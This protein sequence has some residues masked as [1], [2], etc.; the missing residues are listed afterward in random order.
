MNNDQPDWLQEW[1]NSHLAVKPIVSASR[2]WQ[3]VFT[4]QDRRRLGGDFEKAY[5]RLGTVGMWRELH[6]GSV[7]QAVVEAAHKIGLLFPSKYDWLLRQIGKKPMAAPAPT[8]LPEFQA[9]SGELRWQGQFI[10]HVRLQARP[11]NIF[12]ILEAFQSRCWSE[13]IPNP[14]GKDKQKLHQALRSLNKGLK[15]IRFHSLAGATKISWKLCRNSKS[16]PSQLR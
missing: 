6:R 3:Q 1:R 8:N 2:L 7:E 4:E 9:S 13:Q 16:L 11:S 10:R 5:K 12:I 14:L 15:R